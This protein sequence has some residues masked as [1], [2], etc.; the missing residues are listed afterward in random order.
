M[1]AEYPGTL[2]HPSHDVP[3]AVPVDDPRV[4]VCPRPRLFRH[5]YYDD[6]SKHS[7][8]IGGESHA[9]RRA[10]RINHVVDQPPASYGR[11]RVPAW[12]AGAAGDRE[13]RLSEV[14]PS[15]LLEKS[16]ANVRNPGATRPNCGIISSAR[17]QCKAA[18][19]LANVQACGDAA[20]SDSS[21][22]SS[23]TLS[24][25]GHPVNPV[26]AVVACATL[27]NVIRVGRELPG[28]GCSHPL[29]RTFVL[30]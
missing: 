16:V 6:S 26:S 10:Y 7:N 17:L 14:R 5:L 28:N 11:C 27:G 20:R 15:R 22:A 29:T 24:G 30:S 19:P 4:H 12:L 1:T 3:V 18:P 2:R 8:L 23:S 25:E 13:T 21:R 9:A